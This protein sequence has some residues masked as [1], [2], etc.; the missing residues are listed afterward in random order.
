MGLGVCF[1]LQG[2]MSLHLALQVP[3]E[4]ETG[5]ISRNYFAIAA[6]LIVLG[7]APSRGTVDHIHPIEP[8]S[9]PTRR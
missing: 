4:H 3:P 1:L 9:R 6:L 5:V 7:A 8:R 2:G